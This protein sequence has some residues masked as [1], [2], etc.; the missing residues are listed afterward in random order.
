[1]QKPLLP[2]VLRLEQA[3]EKTVKAGTELPD[4]L[5]TAVVLR[6]VQG[7]LKT[8]LKL[9]LSDGCKYADVR[10][11]ILK[12]DRAQAKWTSWLGEEFSEATPMEIDRV[13]GGKGGWNQHKGKGKNQKGKGDKGAQKGKQKGSKGSWKGNGKDGKSKNYDNNKGKGK[14]K[15]NTG[16]G[17]GK[18]KGDQKVC[19]QCGAPGHYA[20]D[21][22]NVVRSAQTGQVMENSNNQG[23]GQQAQPAQ[24]QAQQSG[25]QS[26]QYRVARIAGDNSNDSPRVFDL[27][28]VPTSPTGSVK[29]VQQ[30]YI[31]DDDDGFSTGHVHA[32]VVA[33]PDGSD[34]MQSILLDSG[35]DAT[36]LPLRY[37]QAGTSSTAAKLKLHDAQGREIPVVAMRDVE[38][39]LLDQHGR[40]VTIREHGAISAQVHQPVISFGKLLQSGWGVCG[41]E[42]SL[43]HAPTDTRIP[44]ELRNQSMVVQGWIRTIGFS[45][46]EQPISNFI[47]AVRA[48][49]FGGMDRVAI[50]WSLNDD[51]TGAGRHYS[52]HYM[53]PTL[54]RP[55]ISGRHYRTT[56]VKNGDAWFVLELCE[57]LESIVDPG[58]S[59]YELEG[60]RDVITILTDAEKDPL[61]MGFALEG[62]ENELQG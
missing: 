43:Y 29:L 9:S 36:V 26:T 5:R 52:D 62:D 50:G 53:D 56:L 3:F 22:W 35:A 37:A 40:L 8:H 16:H 28:S 45:E 57:P 48:D 58:A 51:G 44:I 49:V 54:V 59:F 19:Y 1:M 33:I 17:K 55:D 38:I 10:E 6:C 4:S 42:Q 34:D 25:Q 30:V 14:G 60:S 61:V 20:K 39:S 21:C 27:R 2:Q 12:W 18:G 15:Q 32:V 31:G 24:Q 23:Q 11:Q 47:N 41:V 7:Q 46:G 13:D